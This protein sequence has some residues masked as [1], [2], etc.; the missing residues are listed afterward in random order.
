MIG[1]LPE[2]SRKYEEKPGLG[3]ARVLGSDQRA[4]WN[5]NSRAC[6]VEE[7]LRTCKLGPRPHSGLLSEAPNTAAQ[8]AIEF[9]SR[10]S[11]RAARGRP[12]MAGGG[13]AWL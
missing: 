7:H 2:T 13:Q 3:G 5:D 10:S 1:R 12:A 9:L 6:P 11:V 4:G 8:R